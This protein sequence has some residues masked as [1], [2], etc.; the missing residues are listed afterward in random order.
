LLISAG[1]KN[2]W[3]VLPMIWSQS[4]G[5]YLGAECGLLFFLWFRKRI[6]FWITLGVFICSSL[7]VF[8]EPTVVSEA[9]IGVNVRIPMWKSVVQAICQRPIGYGL[10]SFANPRT[11]GQ[12]LRYNYNFGGKYDCATFTKHGD[13]LLP[14][15]NKSAKYLHEA[16]MSNPSKIGNMTIAD[17]PHNEFLWLG[18]E[19]GFHALIILGFILYFIWKRFYLSKRSAIACAST[20][21]IIAFIAESVFQFPLHLSR[22][23]SL[24]PF[25]MAAFYIST[26]D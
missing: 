1:Q 7:I 15:D 20:A 22:I 21:V 8:I 10:D 4:S 2:L 17:H 11:D 9:M 18:Y 16:M 24:L 19:V 26:E 12:V 14:A 23:G 3:H 25:I 5:A 13:N 6:M